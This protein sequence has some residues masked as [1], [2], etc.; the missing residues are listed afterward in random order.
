MPF[1]VWLTSHRRIED[2]RAGAPDRLTLEDL[3]ACLELLAR[4]RPTRA[5]LRP[6]GSTWVFRA[7]EELA[8]APLLWAGLRPNNGP[9]SG[10]IQLSVSA[11][12]PFFM[13]NV[14]ELLSLAA[15]VN[16]ELGLHAFEGVSGRE[17]T[18][19]S[20]R[21]LLDVEG[22]YSRE[23]ARS[24]Q[25]NREQ[26][27]P[28][29]R[30]PLE[31]PAGQ[32]DDAPNM[33]MLRLEHPKPPPLAELLAEPPEG[34]EVE[35]RGPQA[36]WF[37]RATQAPVTWFLLNNPQEVLIWPQWGE[38]PF[39]RTAHSLFDVA[40]RMRARSGGRLIWNGEPV[41]PER[42]SWLQRYPE[43]LG[44]ELLQFVLLGW[45]PVTVRV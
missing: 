23:L 21:E 41:T 2:V 15:L 33:L 40:V 5:A 14:F 45:E 11:T 6:D 9:Q 44:V 18:V 17:V 24:W 39:S 10:T 31:F 8:L 16:E 25:Q 4:S 30:M 35:I 27:H 13:A 36:V 26:L 37:D 3:R 20:H 22:T 7:G 32:Q 19:E 43:L 28:N 34:Q 12:H 42:T 1:S 29:L 38:A